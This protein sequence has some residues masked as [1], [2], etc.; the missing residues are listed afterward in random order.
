MRKNIR[1]LA[2]LALA[3]IAFWP[4]EYSVAQDQ[5]RAREL[6]ESRTYGGAIVGTI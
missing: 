3:Y 5:P 6:N 2:L 1:G 4:V